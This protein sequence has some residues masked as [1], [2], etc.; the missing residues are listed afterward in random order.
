MLVT[1][2]GVAVNPGIGAQADVTDEDLERAGGARIVAVRALSGGRVEAAPL[3]VYVA[4]VLAGE[5]ERDAPAATL[6]A[7]AIAI[8]TFAVFNR[9]RHGRDGFDLCDSTH[10]QVPR[11]ATAATRRAALATSGRILTY[12]G[13]PAEVFYSASCGGRSEVAAAVWPAANLPYSTSIDDDVH[14]ADTPWTLELSLEDI[15]GR[16]G[17]AGFAGSLE[18]IDVAS[19]TDS[20]RA[21][22]LRL[23]GMRPPV[24]S[25]QQF[26]M[27]LGATVLRSTAFSISR[28]GDRVRFTGHGYGHGV[29]MCVIGAGR[30]ARRGES[31]QAILAHYYPG[32][33][34]GSL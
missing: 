22:T 6:E 20:G 26:R 15:E 32:L 28:S 13:R 19:R 11:P 16:L 33:A 21:E 23:R 31:A 14:E 7:L 1:V 34:I 10:C 18:D 2:I 4:Q 24:A 12:Q 25:G 8:R 3:E 17:R 30:R 9:A 5:A 27:T 29:G